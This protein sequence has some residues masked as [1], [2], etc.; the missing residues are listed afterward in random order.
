MK[1]QIIKRFSDKEAAIRGKP[2]MI[3]VTKDGE[4]V[5]LPEKRAKELIEQGLAVEFK[6]KPAKGAKKEESK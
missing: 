3:E 2:Q 6:E 5:E 4:F 1:V